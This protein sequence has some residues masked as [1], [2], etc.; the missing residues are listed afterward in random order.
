MKKNILVFPAGSEVALEIH[1][2]MRYST[3]FNLIGA[4]SVDDHGRF[5]F[6]NYIGGLPFYTEDNFLPQLLEIVKKYKIDAIYPAMDAI[7]KHIK[8]YESYLNCIV[9]GSSL[10]ACTI[11]A[12]KSQTYELLSKESFCPKWYTSIEN[13]SSY[14]VF[15]KPDEGYGSRNVKLVESEEAAIAHRKECK[16]EY[17]YCEYLPG[18]E[19]TID[20]FSN[21]EGEILFAAPRERSRVSGGISVSTTAAKEKLEIFLEAAKKVNSKLLP[22]GAWFFQMKEDA[23]GNLILLEVATRLGGS[24]SYFRAKGVNFALLSAFDAFDI[25]V[26]V[27]TNDYFIELD[28]ALSNKYKL[29]INYDSVYVDFD[30]CIIVNNSVNLNLISFLYQ[31][32][33]K[34]IKI[35]LI[36]RHNSNLSDTL[37]RFRISNLFDEIIHLVNNE[38]KSDHI[39]KILNPIFID[40]SYSE[41]KDVEN[42]LG[43]HVFS[44]DM[45]EALLQ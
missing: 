13:I 27:I 20:C 42:N 1:R 6:D 41:R 22:R 38:L 15:M 19:F 17:V 21:K 32:L 28:R 9:I 36:T 12:S 7:A 10:E 40:D 24:S 2:S 29:S 18:K 45:V 11:A 23:H 5:I 43:V 4:S 44:P 26:G 14:P 8:T 3:H 25:P 39:N 31:C 37:E 16:Q 34:G 33:N 35:I 30:D